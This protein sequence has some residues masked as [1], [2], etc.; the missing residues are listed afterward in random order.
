ML[1]RRRAR[2]SAR[3]LYVPAPVILRDERVRCRDVTRGVRV[4]A[5]AGAD[6]PMRDNM[7]DIKS[8]TRADGACVRCPPP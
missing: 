8:A 3:R 2:F 6:M 1:L 4:D 7:P 5:R